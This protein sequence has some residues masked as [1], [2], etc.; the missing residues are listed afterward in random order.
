[1]DD[2]PLVPIK[3]F[4]PTVKQIKTLQY[5]KE[6]NSVR[7][8]ML[9]AGY[10]LYVA[11]KGN[12]FFK[13]TGVQNAL[14]DLKGYVTNAGLTNQK[15]ADKFKE[16]IDAEKIVIS[17]TEPDRNVPDYDTQ[18]KAFDRWHKIMEYGETGGPKL[19][20]K[21]TVEEFVNSDDEVVK[22]EP[23]Q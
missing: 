12:Q 23:R 22:D 2:K 14:A 17:H 7:K 3:R 10:S 15:I 1:M 19:K 20:R 16:W 4:R 21:L 8:S 11:N 6:G 18:L 5:I 9:K 13:Q